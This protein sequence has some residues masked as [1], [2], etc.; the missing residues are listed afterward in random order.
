[1][2]RTVGSGRLRCPDSVLGRTFLALKWLRDNLRHLKFILWGVVAVFVLLVFVDWGAGGSGPGSPADAAVRVG[3][4]VVSKNEFLSQ[5]RRF[6]QQ[7][8]QQF[9][10]RWNEIRDQVNLYDE[11]MAYFTNRTLLLEEAERAGIRVSDQELRDDILNTQVFQDESGEFAGQETYE[12]SRR[13]YFQM[14]PQEFERSR[15]E[16][17]EAMA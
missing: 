12:R 4:T 17:N 10:E 8:S 15:T 13:G 3:D 7:Y 9:G 5:M 1:M 14:T 16:V 11:T 2:R 6:E